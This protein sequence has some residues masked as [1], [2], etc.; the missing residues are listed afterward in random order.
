MGTIVRAYGLAIVM[1]ISLI[2]FA[3]NPAKAAMFGSGEVRSN[4]TA[5]FTK[6]SAVVS[7][8]KQSL[9]KNSSEIQAWKGEVQ[10][11]KTASKRNTIIAVNEHFNKKIKYRI[12]QKVWGKSDYWATPIETAA[13]GYGD[14]DDYAIAKYFALKE[15]GFD[16]RNMRLVVLKDKKKNEIHAVLAVKESGKYYILDNQLSNAT[17]DYQISYYEP[18]YSINTASWWR[19]KA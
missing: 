11:L 4:D 10:E 3:P 17:P 1:T 9:R 5:S 16:E 2:S 7:R 15:L 19:H 18:I 12:D 6:W 14:C 8:H 13:K